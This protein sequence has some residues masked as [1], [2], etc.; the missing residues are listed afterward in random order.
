M[1][2]RGLVSKGP[3][4]PDGDYDE[5]VVSSVRVELSAECRRA[6][7]WNW[8][9]SV[10]D[11][12]ALP[13]TGDVGN[14]DG[15]LVHA[16]DVDRAQ[17]AFA[18][19]TPF[20]PAGSFTESSRNVRVTMTATCRRPGASTWSTST[21]DLSGP[22]PIHV[23]VVDGE[24]RTTSSAQAC[25]AVDRLEV[26]QAVQ[27]EEGTVPVIAGKRTVVRAFVT[28]PKSWELETRGLRHDDT[29][30]R[31]AR[32]HVTGTGSAT[33]RPDLGSVVSV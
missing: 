17:P 10:L 32:R 22:G 28:A 15:R 13:A 5:A 7:G 20:V 31:P 21:L 2:V 18:F 27:N 33:L 23:A 30:R 26:V 8:V 12:T 14:V 29:G 6:D 1:P 11:I 16:P 24:L 19:L 25:V 9:P 4:V 3:Y